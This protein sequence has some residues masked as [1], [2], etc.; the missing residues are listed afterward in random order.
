MQTQDYRSTDTGPIAQELREVVARAEE[1]M[2]SISDAEEVAVVQL[3]ERA[4]TTM[5][6]AREKLDQVSAQAR[7]STESF[8]RTAEEYVQENP[9]TAVA[10][11]AAAGL[12]V[13]ALLARR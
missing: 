3:R 10:G 9:W 1:L 12:V 8:L 11:S 4:A 13:G 7:E 5:T 6:N 2:Q